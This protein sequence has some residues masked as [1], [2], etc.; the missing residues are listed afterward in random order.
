MPGPAVW[1]GGSSSAGSGSSG[2]SG[3]GTSTDESNAPSSGQTNAP[4]SGQGFGNNYFGR[5]RR[6]FRKAIR[7]E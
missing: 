2:S 7:Q 4:S 5:G 3:N 1:G 6:A